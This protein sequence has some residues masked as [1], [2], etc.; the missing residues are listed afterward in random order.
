MTYSI[1]LISTQEN[2]TLSERYLQKVR[3]EIKSEIY[4]CCIK[5]LCDDHTLR[6]TWEENFYSMSQNVRSHGRL[7]VF[8]DPSYPPDTVLFD[9]HAKTI[10]L[11]NIHYYGWIKSIALSLTG[12]ILEDE[13]G[14]WSVHG[15]CIDIGGKGLALVGPPGC[16]KTTQTYGLLTNP[17]TRVISDDWFFFRVYGDDILSFGS[18]K[19][20][21]IQQDL[22]TIWKEFGGLVPDHA[23][24]PDGR[25]VADV[26]W[27]IG[28]GRILPLTTIN[29]LIVLKRDPADPNVAQTLDPKTALKLFSEKKYFNPHLLVHNSTK[30]RLRDRYIGELLDRTQC[31]C[32]NTTGTPEETQK[33]I[34]SLA[35]VKQVSRGG[36]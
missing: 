2:E 24:D 23:Y 32:V 11:L 10:F 1:S 6:D 5:L 31:Y 30:T 33:L 8:T 21:Y 22:A 29:T 12:D 25:A 13:H 14:I 20:F 15:A 16:G 19:N 27:V 9:P 4:G 34:R 28:K 17:R 7:F 26:R 3:Y 35:D 18:E 36:I